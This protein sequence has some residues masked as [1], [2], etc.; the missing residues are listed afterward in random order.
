MANYPTDAQINAAVPPSGT[1]VRSLTNAVLK[2]L[3]Q[4][5]TWAQVSGKPEFIAAGSDAEE[6]RAA[7]G[8][9]TSNLQ[10][11]TTVGT[12]KEGNYQPSWSQ[13]TGKPSTFMPVIGTT[14]DTAKSGSWLPS[15]SEVSGKPATFTPTIGNTASDA[16]AGNYQPTW[17]DVTGKPL[18]APIVEI[19][20]ATATLTAAAH[21]GKWLK[22]NSAA[23][24][25]ITIGTDAT[26]GWANDT[27]IQWH[28]HGAGV[29]AFVGASGVAILKH[30]SLSATGLGQYAPGGL[31]RVGANEWLLFG[32]MGAA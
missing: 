27:E 26:S 5:P 13:V 25:T 14:S 2:A 6:A 30:S 29:P 20:A 24:Q 21:A 11:G 31:K 23:A 22:L 32:Q 3:A 1:P 19:T 8:A 7:I 15:W 28:Q 17:D 12:A 18:G 9:G 16:K 10:I 4:P